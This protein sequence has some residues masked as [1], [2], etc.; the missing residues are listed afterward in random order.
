MRAA[1]LAGAAAIAF[2]LASQAA[3][4][5]IAVSGNDNKRTLVNGVNT[6]VQD[7]RPDTVSIIDL[8]GRTPRLVAEVA[9]PHSVV[10]P[11]LSV[12]VTPDERL[13][14][15]SS[16]E[17][18]D[19]EN[20]R[21]TI[22]DNRVSVIDLRASPPRVVQTLEV[23]NGPSGISVN[24]AGTL[25]L[26]ANRASG[27]VSVLRIRDG[28]ASVIG[29]VE[30]GPASAGVSHAPFTPDGRHALV[31]RDG[32]SYITVLRI[33]GET[34]TRL[35]RGMSAGL[36]PYAL[37]V[38]PTGA[39]AIVGNVGRASSG[40]TGDIETVS[41]IDLTREPFRVV[42]TVSVGTT[43]EGVMASPDG[44]HAV[45]VVHNGTGRPI[46]HPLRGQAEVKLLR[47]ENN[48][49]RV[50]SAV[51]AGDWVQGMAFSRDGRTLLIGNMADKTIGVYRIEGNRLRDTGQRI[52]VDGGPAALRTA[53]VA[54]PSAP[55][56]RRP[57]RRRDRAE[58]ATR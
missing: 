11:P 44:R 48:R 3:T 37:H 42:D 52:A 54:P 32:D 18:I 26:V 25:A 15:A 8:N 39:W 47:I 43:P 12:A 2:G 38:S 24:R 16:A 10:G 27:T 28:R 36:R 41:L 35:D 19:P 9:A 57:E 53:E 40:N 4:A 29:T 33:E 14:L 6:L 13:A 58:A 20:P 49:I 17:K 56:A 7:P 45:A 50:V 21:R 31:T 46:G 22:P 30:I 55:A 1:L 5:Q 51:P 23:G 34:V